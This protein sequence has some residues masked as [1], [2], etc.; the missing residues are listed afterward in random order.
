MMKSDLD[1]LTILSVTISRIYM[2]LFVFFTI[3]GDKETLCSFPMR[4]NEAVI[5]K[6]EIRVALSGSFVFLDSVSYWK[7]LS[8][9]ARL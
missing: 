5:V 9:A 8:Y 4:R 2:P 3:N 6:R 7:Y 1:D